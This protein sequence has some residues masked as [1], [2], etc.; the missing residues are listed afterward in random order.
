M[1]DYN[2][3]F[4][5][6]MHVTCFRIRRAVGLINQL[7]D[8]KFPLLLSRILQK[9][10]LKVCYLL[11]FI[12]SHVICYLCMNPMMCVLCLVLIWLYIQGVRDKFCVRYFAIFC[13][14]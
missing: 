9:L 14:W 2:I 7:D 11:I 5:G 13:C 10:H 12:I 3:F 1:F 6:G 8:G 4:L